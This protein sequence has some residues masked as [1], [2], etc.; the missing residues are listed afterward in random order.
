MSSTNKK[1]KNGE[2]KQRH[3]NDFYATP[4][5]CTLSL[6]AIPEIYELFDSCD[7]RILEPCAGDGAI[8]HAL[9]Q[10]LYMKLYTAIDIMPI[11]ACKLEAFAYA[12]REYIRVLAPMSFLNYDT[13]EGHKICI[14]NPPFTIW[15]DICKHSLKQSEHTFLLLRL[16]VLGSQKR[17]KFWQECK[18]DIYILSYRPSFT[19]DGKTDSDYYAWFHFHPNESGKWQVIN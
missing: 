14:T 6:L 18:P 8:I 16:G 15:E 17:Y 11:N 13:R 10:V 12:S 2:V 3:L 4:L 19:N 9:S 1:R 7:S 5:K